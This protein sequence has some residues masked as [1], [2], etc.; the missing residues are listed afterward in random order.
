MCDGRRF[1]ADGAATEK[2]LLESWRLN[3]V[4]THQLMQWKSNTLTA[5][6]RP[7]ET[8]TRPLSPLLHMRAV[9][10]RSCLLL[11]N[12]AMSQNRGQFSSVLLFVYQLSYFLTQTQPGSLLCG[13]LRGVLISSCLDQLNS[14][15]YGISLKHTAR[16]QRIQRAVVRV[17]LLQQYRTSS[18]SS[19]ELL[20]QLY[21]LPIEWRIRFNFKLATLTLKALHTGRPPYL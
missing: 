4:C 8:P 16:L 14:I 12:V 2:E 21:W 19:S 9:C 17:V 18:L 5:D 10:C 1:Q 7:H 6:K 20:K 11:Q 3:R 13:A 15:L